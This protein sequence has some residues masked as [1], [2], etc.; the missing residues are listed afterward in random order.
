[1]KCEAQK[2]MEDA[3]KL[4]LKKAKKLGINNP[5]IIKKFYHE[6]LQELEYYSDMLR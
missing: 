1:M 2:M 5:A 6:F 3:K 4:A